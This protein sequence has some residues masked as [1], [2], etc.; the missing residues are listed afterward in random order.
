MKINAAAKQKHIETLK[1]LIDLYDKAIIKTASD[2]LVAEND[3]LLKSKS[4]R[5]ERL[6]LCED[7]I[8]FAVNFMEKS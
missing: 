4:A 6:Q 5:Y 3:K 7:A 1:Q 2:I 8:I